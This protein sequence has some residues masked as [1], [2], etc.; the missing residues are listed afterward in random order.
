MFDIK[1]KHYLQITYSVPSTDSPVMKRCLLC[2]GDLLA[3]VV[4]SWQAGI[5]NSDPESACPRHATQPEC[6]ADPECGWCSADDVSRLSSCFWWMWREIINF[7]IQRT[8][9]FN[10]SSFLWY[11]GSK[12]GILLLVVM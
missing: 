1:K 12:G 2:P 10:F 8:F 11:S 3:Y 6:L 5:R 7:V 9:M 4:P